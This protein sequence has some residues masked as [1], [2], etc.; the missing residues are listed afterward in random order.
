MSNHELMAAYNEIRK[1][2]DGLERSFKN[3]YDMMVKGDEEVKILRDE[4]AGLIKRVEALETSAT[5]QA[6][7]LNAET[8]RE[9]QELRDQLRS[10]HGAGQADAILRL[11]EELK[12][13]DA[14]NAQLMFQIDKLSQRLADAQKK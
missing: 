5:R 6:D 13:K 8:Q 3:C 2:Y 9:L 11:K 10:H 12:K 1:K 4:K 7:A 14:V